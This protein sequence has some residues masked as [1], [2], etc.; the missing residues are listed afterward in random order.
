MSLLTARAYGGISVVV[1]LAAMHDTELTPSVTT[2][3][4]GRHARVIVLRGKIRDGAEAELRAELL[5]AIDDGVRGLLM[6]VSE[7]ETLSASA[8][9]LVRAAS[10]ALD[11]RGGVLL[12]WTWDGSVEE[13]TY[14]LAELRDHAVAELLPVEAGA[15]GDR[16]RP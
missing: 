7:A 8:H 12:A 11:D 3:H 6:D 2:I 15:G 13:P 16:G 14:V 1:S 9:D 5:G 4:L 10:V